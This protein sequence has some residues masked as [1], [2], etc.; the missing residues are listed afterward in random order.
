MIA[1]GKTGGV[2]QQLLEITQYFGDE[3]LEGK[4]SQLFD[5]YKRYQ[6]SATETSEEAQ[7]QALEKI[8]QKVIALLNAVPAEGQAPKA[9]LGNEQDLQNRSSWWK[10]VLIV[11]LVIILLYLVLS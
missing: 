11:V 8:N 2:V 3:Q 5:D 6:E 1:D 7:A 10:P 9:G 4:A